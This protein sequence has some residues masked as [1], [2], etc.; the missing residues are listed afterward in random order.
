L[1]AAAELQESRQTGLVLDSYQ[2]A[3]HVVLVV[4]SL[5]NLENENLAR[6]LATPVVTHLR[7]V[8][9]Q[10]AFLNWPESELPGFELIASVR[11]GDYR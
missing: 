7:R 4:S 1:D 10:T 6:T 5:P 11:G 8:E 9:N 2:T 3:R